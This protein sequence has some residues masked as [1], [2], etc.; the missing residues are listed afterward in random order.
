[1][2][3]VL[4]V[5]LMNS[6]EIMRHIAQSMQRLRLDKFNWS[7]AYLAKQSGVSESTIRRFETLGQISLENLVSLAMTLDSV[8]PL[9][10]L[11]PLQEVVSIKELEKR[12]RKRQRG[13]G[14]RKNP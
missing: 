8:E 10:Q 14:N 13:R 9:L 1:M 6:R 5:K 11:F 4:T 7:R 2:H 12:E 3:S